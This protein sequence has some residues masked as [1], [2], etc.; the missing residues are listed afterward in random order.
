MTSTNRLRVT[1]VRE[2]TLGTTPGTPRMRTRRLV[3][4]GLAFRPNFVMSDEI[5]ADRMMADPIKVG[6]TNEGPINFEFSYPVENSPDDTD[7]VSAMMADWTKT[8]SR[9]NDGTAD[10]VITDIGTT[11][12][13]ITFTTGAAFVVGHLVRATGFATSGNN[14][15]WPVTTGGTTSLVSS[16]ASYTAE[17]APPAAA[18][19]KVV[20]FQGTSG[21]ITATSTG[22]GSTTL[23]FTT[24]GL[25]VGQWI[26]IGGT[27][28]AYRFAT[29]ALNVYARITAISATALTL[30]NLPAAWT[31]DAGTSKTVR[32]F[33]GDYIRN[34][35]TVIG[36]TIERGFMGQGTPSYVAQ[37]GMVAGQYQITMETEQKITGSVTY[38]GMGGDI[39]T[40]SLD[41]SPDAAT[42]NAVMAAHVNVGRIAEGG[43][44]LASPNWCRAFSLSIN[45]NLRMIRSLDD[46]SVVDIQ[47]G[48]CTVTGTTNTYFGDKS[49]YEKLINGTVASQSARVSKN[50]QAFLVTI[51]RVTYTDGSPNAGGKNQD[52]ELPLQWSA[53]ID[54]ATN[55]H[56]QFDRMEY[57]EA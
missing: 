14:G 30:D 33:F 4:E 56:V 21:D 22:L 9:D 53:S 40:T 16:G 1:S 10:S 26:K 51:P 37:T 23:D 43:S 57:V 41:S 28:A 27:G 2:A 15:L 34:G 12:D 54:S 19:I 50:S 49:L 31:T 42:T 24:L 39:S 55:C 5:R 17:T 47:A 13:T 8:P 38:M 32:V 36:Q 20:G 18:R 29:E 7:I 44:A 35:T 11:A 6:E 45:N 48:E 52:V 3:S 25:A 46:V